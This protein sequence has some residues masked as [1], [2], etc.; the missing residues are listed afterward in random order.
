M[1]IA[2]VR[3]QFFRHERH[4]GFLRDVRTYV[5][6]KFFIERFEL[7][8]VVERSRF[9]QFD[10]FEV[11]GDHRRR[12]LFGR[13]LVDEHFVYDRVE[14]LIH[15]TH[16]RRVRVRDVLLVDIFDQR[17]DRFAE[18][19]AVDIVVDLHVLR[20]ERRARSE[21]R[22]GHIFQNGV[23]RRSDDGFQRRSR[24]FAISVNKLEYNAA[25]YRKV[26][27]IHLSRIRAA[28]RSSVRLVAQ[29]FTRRL[30]NGRFLQRLIRVCE[31]FAEFK[32]FFVRQGCDRFSLQ[33]VMV[34]RKFDRRFRDVI[35]P[36]VS[37]FHDACE[38]VC[39]KGVR[40]R[41]E[42]A[43][44]KA[45]LVRRA[46]RR[47]V[48]RDFR[49]L[50]ERAVP[51]GKFQNFVFHARIVDDT[52]DRIP[53]LGIRRSR[54][55]VSRDRIRKRRRINDVVRKVGVH[56][57]SADK[58]FDLARVPGSFHVRLYVDLAERF[59]HD[60]VDLLLASVR[61]L[62]LCEQII[63]PQIEQY[64]FQRVD[65][66]RFERAV[67]SAVD[68]LLR[69]IRVHR[70]QK[71]FFRRKVEIEA[72]HEFRPGAVAESR[73]KVERSVQN[74]SHH[75]YGFFRRRFKQ[76]H[77]IVF[78]VRTSLSG[79]RKASRVQFFADIRKQIAERAHFRHA[80]CVRIIRIRRFRVE[81]QVVRKRQLR[82]VVQCY[83]VFVRT[84][85]VNVQRV[86]LDT[87]RRRLNEFSCEDKGRFRSVDL[88]ETAFQSE[89]R[90]IDGLKH[91]SAA[92]RYEFLRRLFA[93]IGIDVDLRPDLALINDYVVVAHRF[94]F[95]RSVR[96]EQSGQFFIRHRASRSRRVL[97]QRVLHRIVGK[98]LGNGYGNIIRSVFRR[99]AVVLEIC[100][101]RLV[102][103]VFFFPRFGKKGVV[104]FVVRRAVNDDLSVALSDGIDLVSDQNKPCVAR[105]EHAFQIRHRVCV[106]RVFVKRFRTRS[107]EDIIAYTLLVRHIRIGVA[108]KISVVQFVDLFIDL[109]FACDQFRRRFARE[110]SAERRVHLRVVLVRVQYQIIVQHDFARFGVVER[111]SVD[112]VVHLRRDTD[113]SYRI[114]VSCDKVVDDLRLFTVALCV[115]PI[116]FRKGSDL[117]RQFLRRVFGGRLFIR[118]H[119]RRD[120]GAVS[121]REEFFV[122]EQRDSLFVISVVRV[123]I[124][125]ERSH[126]RKVVVVQYGG[127]NEQRHVERKVVSEVKIR[128][129]VAEQSDHLHD[130]R[131]S[132]A[133]QQVPYHAFHRA[134]N[135]GDRQAFQSIENEA[136]IRVFQF[137]FADG[138]R[139]VLRLRQQFQIVVYRLHR[140][141]ALFFHI[142]V[143]RA[144]SARKRRNDVHNVFDLYLTQRMVQPAQID[145]QAAL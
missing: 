98:R 35:A 106:Q 141:R 129:R 65:A 41:G 123:S 11:G 51:D 136:Q 71:F 75:A 8:I 58:R 26:F 63:V 90:R 2:F 49:V 31:R 28:K 47:N 67:H 37:V 45:V 50:H 60:L 104:Q 121:V 137:F 97:V 116:N 102:R 130:G 103:S 85:A 29:N 18:L 78:A 9:F 3:K 94:D 17:G 80:V 19:S 76:R 23:R 73:R 16:Q 138:A 48:C 132:R 59:T 91:R 92:E 100:D 109:A 69:D 14:R 124:L 114:R 135:D 107:S 99:N 144:V 42:F 56:L 34:R 33:A 27:L 112:N 55:R 126:R 52:V 64:V 108:R 115:Q 119:V 6:F 140:E 4:I 113:V 125:D 134:V 81:Q 24:I 39:G 96:F 25:S 89:Q 20:R 13:H 74:R 143:L 57:A 117:S 128:S 12:F 66:Y 53:R 72:S 83:V 30:F 46:R 10:R 101:L 145:I 70:R 95:R 54:K 62:V 105:N 22:A 21:H 131:K 68:R 82:R 77:E 118:I 79:D 43:R 87:R 15:Q 32:F 38:S 127:L 86:L 142:S 40:S 5:F 133:L 111:V 139:T 93:Q 88:R 36:Y 7:R 110:R 44:F 1:R 61:N 120:D 122:K 84:F